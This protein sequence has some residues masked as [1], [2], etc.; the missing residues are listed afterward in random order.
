MRIFKNKMF[1]KWA[2]SEGLSDS[3]LLKAAKEIDQGLIDAVLGG[4]LV[5]KRVARKGEGKRSGFRTIV[6][7]QKGNRTIF[8]YGFPKN[9]RDNI[10]E[11]E[12]RALKELAQDLL[13][14]PESELKDMVANGDLYEV[15]S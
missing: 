4:N 15:K 6:V 13:D 11:Q 1:F 7:F 5:K 12:E 10:N 14:A 2:K 3:T 8:I 9:Q